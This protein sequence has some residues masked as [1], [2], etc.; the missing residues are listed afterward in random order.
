MGSYRWQTNIDGAQQDGFESVASTA[1]VR[2]I[3]GFKTYALSVGDDFT[4]IVD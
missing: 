1:M 2:S 3:H 4:P